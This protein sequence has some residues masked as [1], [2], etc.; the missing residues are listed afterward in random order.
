[1]SVVSV[2]EIVSGGAKV[3]GSILT[4]ERRFLVTFDVADYGNPAQAL[5]ATGIPAKGDLHPTAITG[6][7]RPRAIDKSAEQHEPSSRLIWRVTV[8]YSNDPGRIERTRIEKDVN[9]EFSEDGSRGLMFAYDFTEREVALEEDYS[10]PVKAVVNSVGDKFDP[11]VSVVKVRQ[12][13]IITRESLFYNQA[14]AA[15]LHD[16]LNDEAIEIN[17]VNVA[18]GMARLVKWS[19]VSKEWSNYDG[20]IITTYEEQIEIE[21]AN[22]DGF[23]LQ[24]AN[25]GYRYLKDGEPTRIPDITTPAYLNADG[26]DYQDGGSITPV[27]IAFKPYRRALWSPLGRL[28]N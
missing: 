11:P 6:V 27:Y 4:C 9:E 28:S 10:D 13:V 21:L 26:T 15:A 19:G 16:T 22:Q 5:Y 1:M 18:A 14:T 20:V 8:E 12:R 23:D 25:T 17:G 7:S 24:V 2:T 3:S